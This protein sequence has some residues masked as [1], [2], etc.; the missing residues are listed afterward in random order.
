MRKMGFEDTF[1]KWIIE[2]VC[3]VNYFVLINGQPH[4]CFQP[5]RGLHQ[6][7]LLSRYLFILCADV[8]SHL[9]DRASTSGHIRGI[10]IGNSVTAVTHL[11]FADDSLFFV[12]LMYVMLL[13]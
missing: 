6:G 11:L 12:K 8:L 1:I 10:K 2:T 9:I 3:T 4:G 7:D 5:E 13:S